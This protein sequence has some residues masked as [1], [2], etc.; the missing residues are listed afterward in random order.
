MTNLTRLSAAWKDLQDKCKAKI[1]LLD[2]I[3]EFHIIN[4]SLNNWLNSKARMINILGPI[5]TDP[6]LVQNQMSQIAVMREDFNK[7][8][9]TRDRFNEIGDSL[10]ENI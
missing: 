3:K 1:N 8:V 9:P 2:E 4:D 7:K 10:L 6:R 5:A